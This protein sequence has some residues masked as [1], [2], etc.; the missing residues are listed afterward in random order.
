MTTENSKKIDLS[1][2][3][4][5]ELIEPLTD[6]LGVAQRFKK[7]IKTIFITLIISVILINIITRTY[8]VTLIPS[9]IIAF[10]S[11]AFGLI[12]GFIIGI[13]RILYKSLQSVELILKFILD[14]TAKI[15]KDYDALE[16]GEK[17]MPTATELTDQVYQKVVTIT[18]EK[19]ITKN[20]GFLAKPLMLV[21][22]K[23]R[24]KAVMKMLDK[25]KEDK[26]EDKQ[27]EGLKSEIETG[28]STVAKYSEKIQVYST[29]ASRVVILIG[30]YIR[31]YA[32]I[33]L[34][35][36]LCFAIISATIPLIIAWNFWGQ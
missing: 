26:I 28:I 32:M 9:L 36:L 25:I 18:I 13:L 35:I 1:Q 15:A 11:L 19:V 3:N 31:F 17:E 4:T 34:Y 33:P 7:L 8:E 23:T 27:K 24:D 5:T 29:N 21:Y 16:S 2:Y 22:K 20:F 6:L 30:K 14:L 12:I 10:Y